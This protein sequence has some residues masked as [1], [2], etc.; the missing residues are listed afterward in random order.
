MNKLIPSWDY[1]MAVSANNNA[2]SQCG[3]GDTVLLTRVKTR[4][5]LTADCAIPAVLSMQ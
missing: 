2:N 5:R 4:D 1:I 3:T